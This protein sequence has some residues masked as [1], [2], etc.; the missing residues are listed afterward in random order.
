VEHTKEFHI[1]PS[2]LSAYGRCLVGYGGEL[3]V[4][5]G[6]DPQIRFMTHAW[7]SPVEV[8]FNGRREV[9]NL[10]DADT[11][12]IIVS[13]G[14]TPMVS[15]AAPGTKNA[16]VVG[17][18]PC[19]APTVSDDFTA[20]ELATIQRL[21][22]ERPTPLAI[23]CPRWLGV[24]NSTRNLFGAGAC[25]PIPATIIADPNAVT[26]AELSRHARILAA[27]GIKRLVFS[28]GDLPHL[29]LLDLLR[30][31]DPEVVC[32]VLWHGSYVQVAEDYTWRALQQ[33]MQAAKDG[34]VR[35]ILTVKAG[36]EEFFRANG[37]A[38][39][40]LYNYVPGEPLSPPVIEGEEL[41]VGLWISNPSFRKF[42]YAMICALSMMERTRLHA[43]GLDARSVELID[44]L[45]IPTAKKERTIIPQLLLA[46]EMRRTHIS[47]YVTYSECCPMLPLESL[48]QGVPCLVGPVS[49]L[50]EDS[51][52]LHE[53]L[54]VPYPDRADVIA[55]YA[56]RAAA[57]REEIIAHWAGYAPHY[58]ET[59]RAAVER[60]LAHGPTLTTAL[61][62][63]ASMA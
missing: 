1:A 46:D 24:T 55:A 50:F 3:T 62:A 49:H 15:F 37:V 51:P 18:A 20:D 41:H 5:T 27:A 36:M 11:G 40:L 32:D 23:H 59:A 25:Y 14:R 30:R 28:G 43:A 13:P 34:R 63:A 35:S 8:E 60:F 44:F 31:L 4:R 33:W 47:L 52:Y 42:P 48:Q 53:R 57:E 22:E 56:R 21:R 54:V 12:T 61:E 45:R 6:P 26:D 29:R 10:G 17:P 38:S 16:A 9:I 7:S 58:N 2:D 19:V 39:S